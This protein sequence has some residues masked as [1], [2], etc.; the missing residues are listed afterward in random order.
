MAGELQIRHTTGATGVYAMVFN[1]TGSVWATDSSAFETYA[2]VDITDYDIAFTELGT[3]SQIFTATFPTAIAAG[4]YHIFVKDGGGTAAEAD[5][6]VT[7]YWAE[8]TGSVLLPRSAWALTDADPVAKA[9]TWTARHDR[10]TCREIVE[11]TTQDTATYAMN[12][13][14]MLNPGTSL[15]TADSVTDTS[16]NALTTSSIVLSQDKMAVHF[17]VT[18]SDLAVDTTYAM[19]AT[20]TTTDGTIIARIGTLRSL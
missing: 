3:A 14:E 12:F 18:A 17:T 1:A 11:V 8:W 6:Y 4:I 15:S 7:D 16:A 5:T 20:T 9:R 13:A 19:R 2:T 10:V